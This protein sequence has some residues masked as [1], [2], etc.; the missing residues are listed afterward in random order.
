MA[1]RRQ[2]ELKL[3]QVRYAARL[4]QRQYDAV[5]PLNRLVDGRVGTAME[6][7]AGAGGAA[8]ASLRPGG[9][10]SGVEPTAEERAAIT[11]LSRDLPAIWTAGTTSNQERKQLPRMAIQSA[12]LDGASQA[13]QVEVQIHWRSGAVTSLSVKRTAEGRHFLW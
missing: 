12:Q 1:Q 8:G 11:D 10:R 7:K 13:G 3:E 6:R 2:R 4:V 9:K 5:D